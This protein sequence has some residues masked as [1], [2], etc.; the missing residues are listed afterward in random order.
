MLSC[1]ERTKSDAITP[2]AAPA[3]QKQELIVNISMAEGIDSDVAANT[4]T[5][6]QCIS[7]TSTLTNP[8]IRHSLLSYQ[9][10]DESKYNTPFHRAFWMN[11]PDHVH[12]MLSIISESENGQGM[13]DFAYLEDVADLHYKRL[14]NQTD[15][16]VLS[17]LLVI[18]TA[19]RNAVTEGSA[20]NP[21]ACVT[22]NGSPTNPQPGNLAEWVEQCGV[23]YLEEEKLGQYFLFSATVE[24]L[25][26]NF[27]NE[28]EQG[29]ADTIR[30][31]QVENYTNQTDSMQRLEDFALR[32]PDVE[33][34]VTA[35]HDIT[36][37]NYPFFVDENEP[38]VRAEEFEGF[39]SHYQYL[40]EGAVAQEDLAQLGTPIWQLATV[41]DAEA[42][43]EEM[44]GIAQNDIACR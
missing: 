10:L 31:L 42:Q 28:V 7:Y 22:Q 12:D 43:L 40:A 20:S 25:E 26:S 3:T 34:P 44:C 11:S 38:V 36:G 32:Y 37:G 41:Y 16:P 15:G 6:N 29:W 13:L 24:N 14:F 9:Q 33:F 5:G 19:D 21:G 4:G 39:V 27:N 35:L 18:P 2:V 17:F 30:M 8:E 23:R 1:S